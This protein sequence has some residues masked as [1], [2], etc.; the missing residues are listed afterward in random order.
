MKTYDFTPTTPASCSLPDMTVCMQHGNL[1]T[2][3]GITSAVCVKVLFSISIRKDYFS[4]QIN[5][6]VWQHK[7]Y[8]RKVYK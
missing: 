8:R 4:I 6:T 3:E 1:G 7:I 2:L 5:M